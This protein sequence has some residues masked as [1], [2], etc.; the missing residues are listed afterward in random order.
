[1]AAKKP[2]TVNYKITVK[3]NP[4][5]CG[6]CAGGVQ[7]ANGEAVIPGGRMVEW[8]K[9]HAG[10]EVTEIAESGKSDEPAK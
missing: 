10:Y 1:M 8:F 5:F 7:F 9:E 3:T 2:E 6:I 4:K